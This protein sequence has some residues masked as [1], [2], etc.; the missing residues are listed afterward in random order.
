MEVEWP[1]KRLALALATETSDSGGYHTVDVLGLEESDKIYVEQ[2]LCCGCTSSAQTICSS[3]STLG[4]VG[5]DRRSCCGCQSS[6]QPDV[7]ELVYLRWRLV[8]SVA[9]VAAMQQRS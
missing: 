9:L 5:A 6:T 2:R 1:I 7:L 4:H 8:E 3:W